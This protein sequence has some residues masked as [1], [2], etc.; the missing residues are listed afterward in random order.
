MK[1]IL[2]NINK[3][4]ET[5]SFFKTQRIT[6]LEE[7]NFSIGDGDIFGLIGKNG[8]GKSTLLK[9]I[10]GLIEPNSGEVCFEGQDKPVFGYASCNPRSFFWRIST[11]DNLIFYSKMLG[12]EK[13]NLE[14]NV[15]YIS[16][17]LNI[18]Q[19]LDKPFMH[20]S[21]GQMQ[22]VNIARA[23][24]KKPDV[25]LLDEPTT[26]LDHE[27]KNSIINILASYLDDKKIPAVWCSHDYF[28][29]N[30]ACNKFGLLKDKK[31]IHKNSKVDSFHKLAINYEIEI[32]KSDIK[33]I[34]S[35]LRI[36]INNKHGFATC[37]FS[38]TDLD[39]K[40]NDVIDIIRSMDVKI[41]SLEK[42]FNYFEN[43]II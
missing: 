16:G 1:V 4:F 22:S 27:S 42:N 30:R 9:I 14:K 35:A 32:A 31:L 21:S 19:L 33:K 34:E 8:A 3:E 39:L 6:I 24:L 20:L 43:Y 41:L 7:I 40:L 28:E 11:K 26:S 12:I 23:L 29:L 18:E 15:R 25:L 17:M 38:P 36:K 10:L 37:F 2:K 13:K 5:R